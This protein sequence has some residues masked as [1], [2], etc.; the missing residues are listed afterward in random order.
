MG[1]GPP[2][3]SQNIGFSNNTGPDPLKITKPSFNAWPSSA[4][5][6]NAI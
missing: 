3:K 5:K 6:Q 4:R 2:E 1:L